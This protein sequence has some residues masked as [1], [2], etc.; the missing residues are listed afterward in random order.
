[1]DIETIV[2]PFGRYGK[3]YG[4]D[5]KLYRYYKW[6]TYACY[7]LIGVFAVLHFLVKGDRLGPI[8]WP[9]NLPLVV[10]IGLCVG[11]VF[12]QISIASRGSVASASESEA[13]LAVTRTSPGWRLHR[14]LAVVSGLFLLMLAG[15]AVTYQA[16]VGNPIQTGEA[17]LLALALAYLAYRYQT[18][19]RKGD[20]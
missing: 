13:R 8:S 7:G 11:A 18:R 20:Q 17:L 1:V 3:C 6:F 16:V 15:S 2:C 12:G 14:G 5:S 4:L 10:A 9:H 19:R